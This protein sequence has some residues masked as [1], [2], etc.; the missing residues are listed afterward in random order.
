MSDLD[1][2]HHDALD[3]A[4]YHLALAAAE[5]APWFPGLLADVEILRARVDALRPTGP[6]QR[7]ARRAS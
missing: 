2:A 6:D 1:V 3:V 7:L 5:L 4:A